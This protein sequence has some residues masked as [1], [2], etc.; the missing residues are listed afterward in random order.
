[1]E[2]QEKTILG[3]GLA[4]LAVLLIALIALIVIVCRVVTAGSLAY[5]AACWGILSVGAGATLYSAHLWTRLIAL[6]HPRT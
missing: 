3:R 6:G 1:M 4:V 2:T 5:Y